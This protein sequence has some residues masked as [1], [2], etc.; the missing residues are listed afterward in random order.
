M[1]NDKLAP[2]EYHSLPPIAPVGRTLPFTR[3]LLLNAGQPTAPLS[4]SLTIYP[5]DP[6]FAPVPRYEALSYVWGTSPP[7]TA[8]CIDGHSLAIKPKLEAALRH[9]RLP[10]QARRLWV[11]AVCIDQSNHDEQNRQVG[12]M[13]L[14]Y[15]YAVR[16]VVWLGQRTPGVEGAFALAAR[17]ASLPDVQG[18]STMFR[19]TAPDDMGT[20]VFERR[21][22]DDVPV[23][24]ETTMNVGIRAMKEAPEALQ[25]LAQLLYRE[26]FERSWCLQEVVACTWAIAKCEELEMSFFDLIAAAWWVSNCIGKIRSKDTL[27]FWDSIFRA[28]SE[29]HNFGAIEGSM[30][31]LLH[32]L[33]ETRNFKATDPRDKVFSLLGISD[34]GLGPGLGHPKFMVNNRLARRVFAKRITRLE[35]GLHVWANTQLKP[36]YSKPFMHVYRDLTRVLIRNQGYALNVLSH[37]QH[38]DDPADS[39][40]PSWIPKWF[41]PSSCHVLGPSSCF[42]AGVCDGYPSVV[43]HNLFCGGKVQPNHLLLDGFRVDRVKAVSEIMSSFG[44][45]DP[46]PLHELWDQMFDFPITDSPRL[47]YR[48]GSPVN[49]AF[50]VTLS[51]GA[52]G[53]ILNCE[54]LALATK[55]PCHIDRDFRKL[56]A[57]QARADAA[58]YLLAKSFS[59]DMC[60]AAYRPQER[61]T[62]DHLRVLAAAVDGHRRAGDVD[63]FEKHAKQYC[64]N[65]RFYLT[66]CGYMGI[67]PKM[68]RTGDEVCVLFGGKVPYILRPVDNHHV[69]VGETFV[70]DDAIMLGEVSKAVRLK[71]RSDMLAT[72]F[73]LR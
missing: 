58:A 53:G 40:F 70:N 62:I 42:L 29:R 31:P 57:S 22:G 18:P 27:N 61:D 28:R 7:Q 68:M 8:I 65:R 60:G 20:Y 12:Y 54:E 51:A 73:E 46:L 32:L 11:D 50:C 1:D 41:Q 38:T 10:T 49:L 67:G 63:R 66:H 69:F 25:S 9:L 47:L 55:K 2:Y 43:H 17:L 71:K 33:S 64:Y 56:L 48:D 19:P 37:V 21:S 14:V 35:K 15:K 52:L 44:I 26:Y 23:D 6:S 45:C 30:G 24:R 3:L 16:T 34:E 36:N 59:D 72:T 39:F 5:L 4:G 13:R